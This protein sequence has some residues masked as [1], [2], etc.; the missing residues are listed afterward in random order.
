VILEPAEDEVIVGFYGK[1]DKGSGF[2]YEF[3]I[4]T[5][6]KGVELPEKAYDMAELR[7]DL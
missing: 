7:N 3:G 5:V 2:T 4:L 6:P 1:S